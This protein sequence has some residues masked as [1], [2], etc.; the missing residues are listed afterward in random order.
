MNDHREK[1]DQSQATAPAQAARAQCHAIRHGVNHQPKRRIQPCD[2]APGS[3]S[4]GLLTPILQVRGMAV[5]VST[6]T[7]IRS[8][9]GGA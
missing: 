8:M 7:G 9:G 1:H 2:T 6:E 5:P 3:S 4:H